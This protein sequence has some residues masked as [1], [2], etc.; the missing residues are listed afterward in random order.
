MLQQWDV[1]EWELFASVPQRAAAGE[2][3]SRYGQDVV[4]ADDAE[5]REE[6]RSAWPDAFATRR[7]PCFPEDTSEAQL[8]RKIGNVAV[9][10]S[11]DLLDSRNPRS[12]EV[13]L[14]LARQSRSAA[15]GGGG[16]GGGGSGG[17]GPGGGGRG[18]GGS[19]GRGSD[20]VNARGASRHGSSSGPSSSGG[21]PGG[22]GGPAGPSSSGG[23][24]LG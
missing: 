2:N 14:C 12:L 8:V 24:L 20:G 17:Q 6:H 10:Y 18:E 5:F 21:S 1:D 22:G 13:W 4:F 9:K 7:S 16:G 3:M 23:R 11:Q 19:G 15:V